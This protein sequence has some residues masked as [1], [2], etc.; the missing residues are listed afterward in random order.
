MGT[1]GVPWQSDKN[2][3]IETLRA[4]KGRLTYVA[5][6]LG[7]CYAT[8]QKRIKA[9]SELEELTANLRKEFSANLVSS[10]EDTMM[11]AMNKRSD[12]LGNALKSATY[13]LNTLGRDF[14]YGST[15]EQKEATLENVREAVVDLDSPN[16][17]SKGTGTF[18]EP[19]MEDESSLL[20]QGLGREESPIQ[21]ELGPAGTVE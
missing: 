14:G 20:Y 8:L 18:S 19:L 2:K 5:K 13:I 4:R 3:I 11:F 10:A 1:S 17:H 6:D 7:V 9:D 16:G 12:E 21:D 15:Q